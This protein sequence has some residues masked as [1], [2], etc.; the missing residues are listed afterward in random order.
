MRACGDSARRG[1]VRRCARLSLC[2]GR[3]EEW[4]R[5]NNTTGQSARAP[6]ADA[7]ALWS[8]HGEDVQAAVP[9]VT[10]AFLGF[11]R[12][13]MMVVSR[14]RV[15]ALAD[16]LPVQHVRVHQHMLPGAAWRVVGA[17]PQ[18]RAGRQ[19]LGSRRGGGG[20]LS[21]DMCS[22][23]K[24][25]PAVGGA[26]SDTF[27]RRVLSM[28]SKRGGRARGNGIMLLP[29]DVHASMAEYFATPAYLDVVRR[30]D[31]QGF[32]VGALALKESMAHAMNSGIDGAAV[33][34]AGWHA[35]WSAVVCGAYISG[36][37]LCACAVWFET[38]RPGGTKSRWVVLG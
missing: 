20:G 8:V 6:S 27:G 7:F 36:R 22:A 11:C 31:G 34:R 2:E 5:W 1:A 17:T 18:A 12:A 32:A 26:V 35:S 16:G 14:D 24:A 28:I 9:G 21:A 10:N 25:A 30:A 4:R 38:G 23:V 3:V 37:P 29:D 15:A 33:R 19:A 13:A